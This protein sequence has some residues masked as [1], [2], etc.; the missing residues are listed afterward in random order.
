VAT[1]AIIFG[2]LVGKLDMLAFYCTKCQRAGGYLLR[3]LIE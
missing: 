1:A 2:D 3:Q